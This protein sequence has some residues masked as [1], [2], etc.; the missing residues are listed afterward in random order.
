MQEGK[1]CP[2]Y[3]KWYATL[4]ILASDR[5]WSQMP[6]EDHCTHI[7]VATENKKMKKCFSQEDESCSSGDAK[8]FENKSTRPKMNLMKNVKK[9]IFDQRKELT[10]VANIE[11]EEVT[12]SS[13]ESTTESDEEDSLSEEGS[14]EDVKMPVRYYYPKQSICSDKR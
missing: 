7:L 10:K 2:S 8:T 5:Y 12:I 3:S 13:S 6:A 9:S 1:T 11:V 4:E 14:C